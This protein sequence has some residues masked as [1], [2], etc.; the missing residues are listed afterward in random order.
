[1]LSESVL[2]VHAQLQ[3]LTCVV[4]NLRVMMHGAVL[5]VPVLVPSEN[6]YVGATASSATAPPGLVNCHQQHA[7]VARVP[8]RHVLREPSAAESL[9][10]AGLPTP[11]VAEPS[12]KLDC[13]ESSKDEHGYPADSVNEFFNTLITSTQLPEF[14]VAMAEL[15]QMT[16]TETAMAPCHDVDDVASG[17]PDIP[18]VPATVPPLF[19]RWPDELPVDD[20]VDHFTKFGKLNDVSVD[21]ENSEFLKLHFACRHSLLA[22]MQTS[23]CIVTR[24]SDGIKF[25]LEKF[26]KCDS[27]RKDL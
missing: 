8:P 16:S 10:R 1:M 25:A 21:D 24:S 11:F 23:K 18:A 3:Y 2:A 15:L 9:P 22:V 17:L 7:D 19:V 12:G 6:L 4:S 26:V 14:Q 20:V 27:R 13:S 5:Q